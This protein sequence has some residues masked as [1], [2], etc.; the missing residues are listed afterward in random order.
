MGHV[1]RMGNREVIQSFPRDLEG[2]MLLED[3]D[4]GD[5]VC[6]DVRNEVGGTEFISRKID[7]PV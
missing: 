4:V 1:T 3:H 7:R 6:Q 2:K 5:S